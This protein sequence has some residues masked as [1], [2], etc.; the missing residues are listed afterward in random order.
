MIVAL[1]FV[2]GCPSGDKPAPVTPPTPAETGT[3]SADAAPAE[4]TTPEA[5]DAQSN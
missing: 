3:D 1:G 4:A 5:T 2:A